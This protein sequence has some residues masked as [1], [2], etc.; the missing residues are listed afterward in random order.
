MTELKVV[1]LVLGLL[2]LFVWSSLWNKESKA[3]EPENV[4]WSV[5]SVDTMKYSRDLARE[6]LSSESFDNT[7]EFQVKNIAELGATHVAIATPYDEEFVPFLSKWVENA[8][9]YGLKVWFRG[10]FSGW[11]KWFN[12]ESISEQEHTTKLKE[13][14]QKNPNLFEDGDIF[15]SCPECENGGPGDPR[16]TGKTREF[17]DFLLAEYKTANFEFEK[18]GKKVKA[19]YFSMNGDVATLVMDKSTTEALGDVV[20]VDHY[21]NTPDELVRDVRDYAE[22]SGGKIVLGEVGAPIPD[23]HGIFSEEEQAEWLGNLLAQLVK[24]EG[25]TGINYWVFSGGS[26]ALW[27][28]DGTRKKSADILQSYYQPRRVEIKV[29]DRI[30]NGVSGA[31]VKAGS[32]AFKA[33]SNGEV[34]LLLVPG[35]SEITITANGYKSYTISVSDID[36]SGT[37]NLLQERETLLFKLIAF[38]R[39]LFNN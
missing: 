23:I 29:I 21:V 2:T 26:T 17:R 22:L 12:Y 10:N 30:G 13:F 1:C 16:V 14:I 24:E 33:E 34:A 28:D 25:V 19:N 27:K 7:I 36:E 18:L 37:L 15:T 38:F 32:R 11:E 20:V 6:K 4:W 5:Q 31:V 39:E 8:R 9:K 3:N 35:I